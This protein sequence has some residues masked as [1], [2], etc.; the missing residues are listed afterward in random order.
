M[1]TLAISASLKNPNL[2]GPAPK[3]KA[4]MKLPSEETRVINQP[5][6]QFVKNNSLFYC[7]LLKTS[8]SASMAA[9][10]ASHAESTGQHLSKGNNMAE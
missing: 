3:S 2:I 5:N 9:P 1:S 4:T 10:V 6:V 7:V 8:I